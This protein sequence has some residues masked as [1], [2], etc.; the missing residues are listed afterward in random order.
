MIKDDICQLILSAMVAM[1]YLW[2][3]HWCIM[4]GNQAESVKGILEHCLWKPVC[5]DESR[6]PTHIMLSVLAGT[7]M[8][9]CMMI[10]VSLVFSCLG[11]LSPNCIAILTTVLVL[12]VFLGMVAKYFSPCLYKRTVLQW[13]NN[14]LLIAFFYL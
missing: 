1:V 11:F 8:Q 14:V 5:G 6:L 7:G 9:L 12:Y 2:S 13:K 10:L 4:C 3:P